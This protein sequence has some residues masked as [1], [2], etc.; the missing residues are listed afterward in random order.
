MNRV[1]DRGIVVALLAAVLTLGAPA[2]GLGVAASPEGGSAGPSR[3]DSEVE[4]LNLLVSYSFD[5][6]EVVTGPDTFAVFEK[7]R[8]RVDL[9]ATFRFSGY[10]SVE[11]Q[12]V[13]G[14]G[15]FPELQGYFPLRRSGELF[16]HFAILTTDA[17][18]PFNVALAGP[19][20]FSVR[21]D[22]IGFWLEAREG[23]LFH[24][25]D[26]MPRRLF[27][28]RPFVWYVVDIRYRVEA[29]IYD[30]TIHEEGYE[31]P[32]ISLNQQLNASAQ[33]G[34][35][36]DKFSF[37]GDRGE[38]TSNVVYYVDDVVLSADEQVPLPPFVAP[39][40]RKMFIDA[41][42]EYERLMRAQPGCLPAV[43]LRDLGIDQ[44]DAASLKHQQSSSPLETLTRGGVPQLAPDPA[45]TDDSAR[46]LGA[47]TAWAR[48]CTFLE[49]ERPRRALVEFERAARMVP[50]GRIYHLSIALALAGLERW[51]E[52]DDMLATI[53]GDWDRDPRFAVAVAIIGLARG[54]LDGVLAALRE[55]AEAEPVLVA[56][57]AEQYFFVLIWKRSYQEAE[58]LALRMAESVGP[59]TAGGARWLGRAADAAQLQG[60]HSGALRRYERALKVRPDDAL[61]WTKLADVHFRLGDVRMERFCREKIYGSL[62]DGESN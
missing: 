58:S 36:V 50:E 22:G 52:V 30:L 51:D 26:S 6:H 57:V 37:I 3:E 11:I 10:R 21:K 31:D 9:S 27:P 56:R 33:P 34:S 20:W 61:L 45:L 60:D 28:L 25:S 47:A 48:G 59:A 1:R 16:A 24:H 23:V 2:A 19:Q 41:W 15:Q 35:A 44:S 32:V 43:D 29:G 8:G 55:S 18:E 12:D 4:A 39:G 40:R 17:M 13:A 14:D 53:R 42:L 38:D 5:D 46:L 7:A 54:D 62:R 49:G